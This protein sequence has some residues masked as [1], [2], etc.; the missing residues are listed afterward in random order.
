MTTASISILISLGIL[1]ADYIASLKEVENRIVALLKEEGRQLNISE[2]ISKAKTA[3]ISRSEVT[4]RDTIM[5]AGGK[6]KVKIESMKPKQLLVS[7][8]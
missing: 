8:A 1:M 4:I 5:S 6:K 2:L 3:G 7:P